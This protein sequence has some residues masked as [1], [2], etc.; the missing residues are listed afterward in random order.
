V[1][2]FSQTDPW[3]LPEPARPDMALGLVL[4][5][6]LMCTFAG[7]GWNPEPSKPP[8][9]TKRTRG[10]PLLA[11]VWVTST[12]CGLGLFA[13]AIMLHPTVR[14]LLSVPSLPRV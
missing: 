1:V 13:F 5:S 3:P 2:R 6:V 4:S 11:V 12:A 9:V 7:V 8:P 10:G 14:P